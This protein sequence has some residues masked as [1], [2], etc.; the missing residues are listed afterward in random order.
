MQDL[1][2]KLPDKTCQDIQKFKSSRA[3]TTSTTLK[4]GIQE[5]RRESALPLEGRSKATRQTP[6]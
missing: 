2:R 6:R 1:P 3:A 4:D 5:E